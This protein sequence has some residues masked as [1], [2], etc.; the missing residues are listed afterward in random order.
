MIKEVKNEV[1]RQLGLLLMLPSSGITSL[2]ETFSPNLKL[3]VQLN[4]QFNAYSLITLG[5]SPITIILVADQC[6]SLYLFLIL[7][8]AYV[9]PGLPPCPHFTCSSV[10]NHQPVLVG[11][12]LCER[13]AELCLL[14]LCS[15][16]RSPRWS[17]SC[18]TQVSPGSCR[19]VPGSKK[20]REIQ[21]PSI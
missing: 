12:L 10:L 21:L 4:F 20:P 7:L 11:L 18:V 15:L 13:C 5:P 6:V 8:C 9:S 1:S 17:G 3:I 14:C 16:S 2:T 19:L